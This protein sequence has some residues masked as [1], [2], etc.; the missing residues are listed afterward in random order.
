[1]PRFGYTLASL[2]RHTI[3]GL[4]E[5]KRTKPYMSRLLLVITAAIAFTASAFAQA[6]T[7]QIDPNHSAARFSVHLNHTQPIAHA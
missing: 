4:S 7:W 6:K 3:P 2:L 5:T 1:M